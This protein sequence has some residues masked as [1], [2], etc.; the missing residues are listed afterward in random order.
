MVAVFEAPRDASSLRDGWPVACQRRCEPGQETVCI[1]R[2][3]TSRD[4]PERG[5]E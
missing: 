2:T 3:D 1:I 5:G 4:A